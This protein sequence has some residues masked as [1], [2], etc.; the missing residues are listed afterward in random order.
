MFDASTE[1]TAAQQRVIDLVERAPAAAVASSVPACPDWTVRDLLSHMVG[2][3]ADV[4]AGHEPD[5]HNEAWT[6]AQVEARRDRSVTELVAEW[7]GITDAM[8]AHIRSSGDRPVNDIVIHEQDLRGALGAHGATDTPA[9]QHVRDRFAERL[10]G[11]IAELPPLELRGQ[12]WT[13]RSADGDPAAVIAAT[14]ADLARALVSRRSAAQLRSWTVAGD[15]EPYLEG[16]AILGDLPS[17][18]LHE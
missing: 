8:V 17:T 7:R 18:D 12:R 11:R 5:D 4:V 14:D 2:I 6:A 9:A 15:I 13:W 16:F 1:W 3:G 10:A